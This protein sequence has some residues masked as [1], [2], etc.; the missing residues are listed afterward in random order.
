MNHSLERVL[1][2]ARDLQGSMIEA[3]CNAT[4]EIKPGIESSLHAARDLQATL[5]R[6]VE[7]EAELVCTNAMAARSH[8][9]DYMALGADALRGSSEQ[10]RIMA[11][12]MIQQAVKVVDAAV[13]AHESA[14]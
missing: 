6:H 2:Q 13:A 4:H 12:S 11:K 8:L 1:D 5:T 7:A 14:A 3:F 10:T 9:D